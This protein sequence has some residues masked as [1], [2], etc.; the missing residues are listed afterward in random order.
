M[1]PADGRSRLVVGRG[2]G[3]GHGYFG[4]AVDVC[5]AG[6][7]DVGVRMEGWVEGDETGAVRI[8]DMAEVVETEVVDEIA[9]YERDVGY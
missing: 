8:V 3:G 2:G 1:S 9:T 4:P 7:I 6:R 5:E